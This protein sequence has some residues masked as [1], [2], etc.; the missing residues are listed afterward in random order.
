MGL[1]ITGRI[2]LPTKIEKFTVLKSPHVSKK[3]RDQFARVI[4]NRLLQ[5]YRP[6][7]TRQQTVAMGEERLA[8]RWDVCCEDDRTPI[9]ALVAHL[10]QVFDADDDS[11]ETYLKFVENECPPGVIAR[12]TGMSL[13]QP[14]PTAK[15]MDVA[16]MSFALV[17]RVSP[18]AA[19]GGYKASGAQRQGPMKRRCTQPGIGDGSIF[20]FIAKRINSPACRM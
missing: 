1:R 8:V 2:P 20:L 11:L 12:L 3:H 17:Y 19:T 4:H 9:L 16:R 14:Q 6:A 5:V 10:P 15:S 13:T 18:R 7:V